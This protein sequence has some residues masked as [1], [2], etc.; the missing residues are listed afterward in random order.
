LN[1]PLSGDPKPIKQTPRRV[2]MSHDNEEKNLI[3]KMQ[4]QGIIRKSTS[5]WSSPLLLVMKKNGTVRP[6][7]DYRK[8]TSVTKKDAFPLPWVPYEEAVLSV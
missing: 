4:K 1:N 2:P 5:P 6:C 3:D 7:V 8:L